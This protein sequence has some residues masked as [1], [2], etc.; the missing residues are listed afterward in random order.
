MLGLAVAKKALD[1]AGDA[2]DVARAGWKATR[3]SLFNR[4]V[5]WKDKLSIFTDTYRKEMDKIKKARGEKTEDTESELDKAKAD[6]E[7]KMEITEDEYEFE[8]ASD[9]GDEEKKTLKLFTASLEKN[10]KSDDNPALR[11]ALKKL[12]EPEEGHDKALDE[13]EMA[14]FTGAT[15]QTWLDLMYDADG[16]RLQPKAFEQ[17]VRRLFK[18]KGDVKPMLEKY[19]S[20]NFKYAF[21][22]LDKMT[23]L[24][25]LQ[26]AGVDTG[27]FTEGIGGDTPG[28]K[29]TEA[30][31]SLKGKGDLAGAAETFHEHILKDTS[32][33]KLERILIRVRKLMNGELTAHNLAFVLYNID[34]RDLKNLASR[35]KEAA[36]KD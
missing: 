7:G 9:E 21:T 22:R 2:W 27:L 3:E 36:K 13:K 30:V 33:K 6:T 19:F 14:A 4:K 25:M 26:T 20:K 23:K 16:N 15:L 10:L 34:P 11:S 1:K 5:D 29:I 12:K 31:K 18:V 8:D 28:A 17:V 35:M 24:S 32:V